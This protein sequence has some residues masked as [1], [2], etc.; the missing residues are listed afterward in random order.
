MSEL[1]DTI[2]TSII[3]T[4]TANIDKDI[5]SSFRSIEKYSVNSNK[6]IWVDAIK[7][8]VGTVGAETPEA[9]I[10]GLQGNPQVQ[11]YDQSG[12][13]FRYAEYDSI[14]RKISYCQRALETLTD[15]ILAPDD[16][17]K[18]SIQFLIDEIYQA[19]P[20]LTTTVARLK[21]IEKKISFDDKVKRIVKTTLKKGDNFIE[22]VCSPKGQN[23]LTVIQ[24][25]VSLSFNNDIINIGS[26]IEKDINYK[27][28]KEDAK[29]DN[30]LE[31]KTLKTKIQLEVTSFGGA[32]SGMGSY[33][34]GMN[35]NRQTGRAITSKAL[36]NKPQSL[37][38]RDDGNPDEPDKF[39]AK[40][41]D[42]GNEISNPEG[43][44][45]LKLKDIFIAIHDPKFIIRLE[46]KRFKTCLGYLVFP[47]LDPTLAQN[48]ALLAAGNSTVDGLCSEIINQISTK[49]KNSNDDIMIS[50]D[51][52]QTILTYLAMI[53][54][55]EDLKVRYVPPDLMSHWRINVDVFDPYGESILECVN[56]DCRLLMAL[57]TATTIK[58]LT[59]ATDKRVIAV[60]TG[61]PR[62][63]KNSIEAVKEALS[64][65]RV[66]I[67]SMG[68]IDNIPSQI[69]TFETIYIPMRDGKRFVEF[70]RME[71]G[72]N[73]T[74]DVENLKFIRDNIVANL[75]VPA[76][77]L[78]LEEN[79]SNRSLLTVENINF[80]RTIISYQKELS[81]SL[82]DIF[83]KIYELLYK[84]DADDMEK[85]TVTFQEPKISPYE[86]Q[87]EY[88]E[89]IQRLIEALKALGIPMSYLK[90]KYLPDFDWAAIDK[91]K[92]EETIE[93]ETGEAPSDQEQMG[94]GIGGMY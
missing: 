45:E 74:E 37:D 91:Y 35:V 42:D 64:K 81:V 10:R 94:G 13:V 9:I 28:L 48:A 80:C 38:P 69:P 58:R 76:P 20:S 72:M 19:N 14:V 49:L 12:R 27:V 7:N 11:N 39:K 59:Y 36:T 82:K 41:D 8:L 79:M 78:G 70:D 90:K 18:R 30:D 21:S 53:Q 86:H 85:I 40:F 23:S 44:N 17:T 33:V 93:Q 26:V 77:Y 61:L 65:K 66:S 87:M 3:G 51:M 63:A 29:N 24:E 43:K 47:K 22:V 50:D 16:I 5:D 15:N 56:F 83:T 4:N 62:D 67:D 55:N 6:N 57:K 92:A 68:S 46:T 52:K 88:V 75:G 89:Q 1:F 2:K 73:P 32:L 25:G 60:E 84:K 54:N 34:S 71:W 31:E